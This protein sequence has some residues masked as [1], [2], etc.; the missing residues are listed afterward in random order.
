MLFLLKLCSNYV[1]K[2]QGSC[3]W[4]QERERC[5]HAVKINCYKLATRCKIQVENYSL[6]CRFYVIRIYNNN[7]SWWWEKN[8]NRWSTRNNMSCFDKQSLQVV[9]MEELRKSMPGSLICS[10]IFH[11][12]SV[13]LSN[14]YLD[15]LECLFIHLIL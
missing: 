8:F 11:F 3:E 6:L 2:K 14:V 5:K 7:N 1:R 9:T 10:I 12:K 4:L 15:C 13:V